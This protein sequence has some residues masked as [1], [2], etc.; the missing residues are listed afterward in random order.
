[1]EEY[2][3]EQVKELLEKLFKETGYIIQA[4]PEFI[5]RDDGTYSI[6]VVQTLQKI[7]ENK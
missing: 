1:M 2:T 3:V 6:I 7:Q 5:H 4:H